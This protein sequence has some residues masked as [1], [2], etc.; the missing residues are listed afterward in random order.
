MHLCLNLNISESEFASAFTFA[1]ESEFAPA[2]AFAPETEV[3]DPGY[4]NLRPHL[5]SASDFAFASAFA[6][7]PVRVKM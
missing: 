7:E 6:P 3:S 5:H 2:F 1:S 4:P